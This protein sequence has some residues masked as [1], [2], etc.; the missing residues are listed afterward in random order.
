VLTA[1]LGER[2]RRDRHLIHDPR[3]QRDR[4]E[5]GPRRARRGSTRWR[6]GGGTDPARLIRAALLDP[7]HRA[8]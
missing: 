5:L 8:R 3:A 4:P 6:T 7:E 2:D 1:H